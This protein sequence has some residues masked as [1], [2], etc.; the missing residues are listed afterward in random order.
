VTDR[1][2]YLE[3]LTIHQVEITLSFASA[4]DRPAANSVLQRWS[5]LADMEDARLRLHRLEMHHPLMR[6]DALATVV[7]CPATPVSHFL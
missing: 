2:I 3:R 6:A 4:L 7:S 5:Y 1:K